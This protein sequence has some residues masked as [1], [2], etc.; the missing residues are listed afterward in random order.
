MVEDG[1]FAGGE[2][3]Q[4]ALREEESCIVQSKAEGEGDEAQEE[5]ENVWRAR[6][7]R[8]E[9]RLRQVR[10]GSGTG[11]GWRHDCV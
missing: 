10:R 8:R 5:R 9:G 6:R 1:F 2:E 11:P 3:A 7:I 4:Q